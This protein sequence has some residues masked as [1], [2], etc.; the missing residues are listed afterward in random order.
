MEKIV[1]IGA[2][3]SIKPAIVK[4]K[5]MGFE[6]HVFAWQTGDIGEVIADFFYPISIDNKE[7]ILKVCKEIKPVGV[8]SITS[9]FAVQTVNYI[10]CALGFNSNSEK[11]DLITRNKYHM[12]QAFQEAKIATPWFKRVDKEYLTGVDNENLKDLNYPLMIK[13]TDRWSSKGVTRVDGFDTFFDSIN[14][15]ISESLEGKAIIEEFIEGP[16]YSCECISYA[17]K[18]RF[19]AFT[20]KYTT[21]APSYIE[22]GHRQPSDIPKEIQEKIFSEVFKALDAL[23]IEYGASHTE[24]KLL[25][26]GEI[27]IIEVGARMAGDCIGTDLVHISTGYDYVKLVIDVAT[28]KEPDF[29]RISEPKTAIIKFILDEKDMEKLNL[30]RETYPEYI[31]RV[32]HIVDQIGSREVSDSSTRFGYF[33]IAIDSDNEA[34]DTLIK[35]LK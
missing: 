10:A 14:K 29:D 5:E 7:E 9:D 28:G 13:P 27:R 32:S 3:E 23:N 35:L 4:A 2:N 12:R 1:I 19:L 8:V 16:E 21:G 26:N 24:F 15:A 6:T 22:T 33:I 17:G 20:K 34:K 11:T 25:E 30:I 31:W 18:H